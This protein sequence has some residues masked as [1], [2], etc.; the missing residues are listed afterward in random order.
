[1]DNEIGF[2]NTYLLEWYLYLPVCVED[3]VFSQA[4]GHKDWTIL[5]FC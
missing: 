4:H 3:Q 1:M 5:K 2:P